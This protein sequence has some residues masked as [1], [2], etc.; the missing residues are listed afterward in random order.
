MLHKSI[1]T[2]ALTVIVFALVSCQNNTIFN[3][4]I[5]I[6]NG[7]WAV[8]EAAHFTV[9]I[10]DTIVPYDFYITV[11]NTTEYRY[12]NL[13]VFLS[14]QFPNGNITR[15]T[16]ECVLADASG[17]W[18]GKGWGN[19]KEMDILLKSDLIFPL[20]GRYEFYIQQA[21]RNDPLT[22]INRIGIR[23]DK[24]D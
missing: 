8:N 16:I 1:S 7:E 6:E 13:Y 14:T 9:D 3:K 17:M 19:I 2:L 20:S 12:S 11:Q 18:Y 21:M 4:I 5:T 23:L 10:S 22:G 15:D 24:S